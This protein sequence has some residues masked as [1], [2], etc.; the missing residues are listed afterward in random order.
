METE[1]YEFSVKR[2]DDSGKVSFSIFQVPKSKIST[3]LEGLI[4]IKEN[5]DQTLAFRFSCTM[6]ICGSCSMVINGKPR[7]ACS[8]IA[9]SLRSDSIMVEPLSHYRVIKDLIV[10]ID[11]FFSKYR[12]I[13]PYV[14]SEDEGPYTSELK[15]TREEEKEYLDFSLCIKCGLCLAACPTMGSDPG[16]LGPAA[17]TAALRYNLDSRDNGEMQRLE[18]VGTEDGASR[19]HYAGECTEVCPKNVDPSAAIQTLRRQSLKG[20]FSLL[21]R[22]GRKK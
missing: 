14:I 19:C 2:K 15:Q 9:S 18:V 5:I 8:T 13:K 4:Y 6:E 1:N 21:L 20:E 22:G 7:M 11:P 12:E 16:Y 17:L 3:V 10:D